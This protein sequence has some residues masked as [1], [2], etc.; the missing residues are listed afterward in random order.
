MAV[1]IPVY[2]SRVQLDA[3]AQ[4]MPRFTAN[5]EIGRSLQNVGDAMLRLGAHWQQKQEQF[6]KL[7][8]SQQEA[9][10]RERIHQIY[11]EET[12]KFNPLKD[13]PGTLHNRIMGRINEATADLVR[14]APQS[15]Q[16]EAAAKAKGVLDQHSVG[17]ATA[18]S[19]MTN[20]AVKTELDRRVGEIFKQVKANPDSG[21]DA[22]KQVDAE[23]ASLD[24][25]GT[26]TSAQKRNMRDGYMSGIAKNAS[27]G[28]A[29]QGRTEDGKAFN[30]QF[31]NDRE[32]EGP[33]Q[34]ENK[35][36]PG[37]RKLPDAT[38]KTS[39]A[40]PPRPPGSIPAAGERTGYARDVTPQDDRLNEKR[41]AEIDKKPEIKAAIEQV[42]QETG[43]DPRVLKV[44]AS[45]ESDGDPNAKSTSGKHHGLFQLTTAEMGMH[46]KNAN[47]ND[48][49]ANTRVYVEILKRN[50]PQLEQELGRP[51]TD[52]E[53]YLSH[54]QGV[55]GSAGHLKNPDKPAWETMLATKEGQE[56]GKDWAIKAVAGNIPKD[57]LNRLYGGDATKVTS[58]EMVAIQGTRFTGGS[59]DEAVTTARVAP[60]P[61]ERQ[62]ITADASG[63][64][65]DT[66]QNE[67]PRALVGGVDAGGPPQPPQNFSVAGLRTQVAYQ[68]GQT[69]GRA[70]TASAEPF[71]ALVFHN[72]GGNT[73]QSALETLKGDSSRGGKSFGYHFYIDTDGTVYQGAP[74]N[75]RTNHIKPSSAA[76]RTARPDVNNNNAIGIAYVGTGKPNAAQ[77]AS[78]HALGAGVVDQ[79]KIP[80]ENVLGHGE[81]QAGDRDKSEGM[82]M[83]QLIRSGVRAPVLTGDDGSGRPAVQANLSRWRMDADRNN[84]M[85]D[86]SAMKGAAV[87]SDFDKKLKTTLQSDIDGIAATGKG[88]VLSKDMQDHFKTDKLS[89]DFVSNRLGTG[90]ALTWQD[91]RQNAQKYYEATNNFN[92][93][94]AESILERLETLKPKEG[95]PNRPQEQKL[96]VAATKTWLE[97]N[98][99]RNADAAAAA[100]KFPDVKAARDAAYADPN[101]VSK[102]QELVIARMKAMEF[103]GI[104]SA[105]QTPITKD[106]ARALAAPLTALTDPDTA[107]SIAATQ[108]AKNVMRV[109]GNNP[110]LATKAMETVL[111]QK[112]I[113][114]ETVAVAAAQL[115]AAKDALREDPTS[116]PF[117]DKTKLTAP[118]NPPPGGV[119][120]HDPLTGYDM[121]EGVLRREASQTFDVLAESGGGREG[122]FVPGRDVIPSEY[123]KTL[124]ANKDNQEVRNFFDE[125]Y[126][127]GASK[128]FIDRGS[129][130]SSSEGVQQPPV[131]AVEQPQPPPDFTFPLPIVPEV[132]DQATAPDPLE[133]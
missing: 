127:G 86:G 24:K 69:F 29:A 8:L 125:T 39:A 95:S 58:G 97:I 25:L 91:S 87:R 108:V 27:D 3:A 59:I 89:F 63:R 101:N 10:L 12:L 41:I 124:L 30:E 53:L 120:Y 114:K 113:N 92:L 119:G 93:M 11:V 7:Q 107:H 80:T 51:P 37:A 82:D 94:S 99:S 5:T 50:A 32:K 56:K 57:V 72:T 133:F 126:G 46:G 66:D 52:K 21:H 15:Q 43:V 90:A 35:E 54:Q 84:T 118:K 44:A 6:D 19:Q 34:F 106:E 77:L 103:L 98:K 31:A 33:V 121:G 129:E 100:D 109:T 85:L 64:V 130:M 61:G 70:A 1:R 9:L 18:E 55:A 48:P 14:N 65:I 68:P 67:Q 102:A 75:A 42:A 60:R 78:G 40:E 71:K 131:V 62:T 122:S 49:V 17:A 45:I 20:S 105:V 2:E 115:Q 73:L 76:E 13:R 96:F 123:I 81:V 28:F 38:G 104:S 132:E 116:D 26:L 112:N 117:T 74:L 88:A 110:E 23:I 83:V 16:K 22:V 111:R 4:T 36:V 47:I 128:H 79:F